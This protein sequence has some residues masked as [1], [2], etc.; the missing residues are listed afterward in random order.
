MKRR[1]MPAADGP[2][3]LSAATLSFSYGEAQGY[4]HRGVHSAPRSAPLTSTSRYNR[5]YPSPSF[6]PRSVGPVDERTPSSAQDSAYD[7][8][9]ESAVE[10]VNP[11]HR[12][13]T[14]T[15]RGQRTIEARNHDGH[16]DPQIVGVFSVHPPPTGEDPANA[17]HL[18]MT[19]M[20]TTN[21]TPVTPTMTVGLPSSTNHR[22]QNLMISTT[23]GISYAPPS[24]TNRRNHGAVSANHQIRSL[25]LNPS[26]PSILL[27]EPMTSLTH[28]PTTS[29]DRKESLLRLV[30]SDYPKSNGET[31]P[32]LATESQYAMTSLEGLSGIKTY[33]FMSVTQI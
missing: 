33:G 4:V 10:S 32:Q 26:T 15:Y 6:Q 2:R 21:T 23:N 7:N 20:N 8:S 13:P 28:E 16:I 30:S 14:R 5:Q 9:T 27:T 1:M 18:K 31:V 22:S 19:E 3:E 12:P 17:T 24:P 29:N 25:E 11:S